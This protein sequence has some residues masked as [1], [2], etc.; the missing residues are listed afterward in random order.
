MTSPAATGR[1]AF[2]GADA[3]AFADLARCVHC[4]LCLMHCPTFVATGLETESPRGRL[5]LMRAAEEGRIPLSDGFVGHMEL[6]LQCRNCES[7]CPSGVPFGRIMEATRSQILTQGKGPARPRLLRRTI[8]RALFLHTSVLSGVAASLRLYQ[9][10]GLRWLVQRSGVLRLAPPLRE[11][12][13][14]MPSLSKRPFRPRRRLYPAVGPRRHRVAMFVGCVMPQMYAAS[15]R[16][17][18]NVMRRNGCDVVLLPNEQCCGALL[19]HGG[20]R[21]AARRLAR[22]NIDAV[23]AANVDALIVNAAGCGSMLKEYHEL[24]A[25][26][27]AYREKAERFSGMVR[28]VT[29]FLAAHGI[30]EKRLGPVNARVTYQDSCHLA[31]AQRVKESPRQLIRAI[32]GVEFV[33]LGSD[34]CCG[35]A[36]IYN[37]V[38]REMSLQVLDSKMEEVSEAMPEIIVTANPGCMLQLENGVRRAGLKARVLHVVDLLEESY[39]AGAKQP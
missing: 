3:P 38:R 11:L 5:Y 18:L 25:H 17:T 12:E 19:V 9:R 7:V 31:H 6:C 24:L 16:A 30:D 26:D 1:S 32:P 20:D 37:V 13:A 35:S 36:G 23:L 15:E 27:E 29:E 22:R 21:E 33:E 10:S 8:T 39:R 34:R 28:D 4:G 2:S 14:M